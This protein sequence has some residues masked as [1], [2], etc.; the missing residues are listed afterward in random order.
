MAAEGTHGMRVQAMR[1]TGKLG[2]G[3]AQPQ[4]HIAWQ[5]TS[6]QKEVPGH[7]E[8]ESTAHGRR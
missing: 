1:R 2:A 5:C 7:A 8:S 3:E 4:P 6:R